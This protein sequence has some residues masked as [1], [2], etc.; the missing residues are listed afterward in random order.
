MKNK[1]QRSLAMN[2]RKILPFLSS[3]LFLPFIS[4]AKA[5]T[6]LVEDADPSYQTMLTKDG[7]IVKVR[8]TTVSNSNIVDKQLS[9]KSL[10]KWLRKNNSEG[11][12]LKS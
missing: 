11:E 12:N 3:L 5:V 1:Q 9:N 6:D 10:L 4:S 7:K 8:S 2:R